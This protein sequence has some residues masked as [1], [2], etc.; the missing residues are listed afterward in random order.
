MAVL[1]RETLAPGPAAARRV[2][3]ALAA[4]TAR[5]GTPATARDDFLLAAS[6]WIV[7]L[8]E[9]PQ[10]PPETVRVTFLLTAAEWRLVMEDSGPAFTEIERLMT[11]SGARADARAD[12]GDTVSE[13]GM[14]LLLIAQA[15]P[16][17]EYAPARTPG[18]CNTL[19]LRC[20]REGAAAHKP[21]V[22][23]VDDD[24]TSLALIS[25]YLKDSYDIET[26]ATAAGALEAASRR[27]PDA[28]ISDIHMPGADGFT[29]RQRFAG[30]PAM[31]GA[32]FI[33]LSA[34]TGA[35]AAARAETLAVDDVIAK[36]VQKDKLLSV[37]RRVLVRARDLRR[38]IET[39][40]DARL[41]ALLR[42]ALAA[43]PAGWRAGLAADPAESGSGDIIADA[44][45]GGA[46]L[47]VFADIMGHGEQA[48]VFAQA[49]AGFV[50]GAAAGAA[51]AGVSSDAAAP[52]LALTALN[53]AFLASPVLS[54]TL[55]TAL[56]AAVFPDGRVVAAA[57][58]HPNPF[59][60]GPA[61]VET[62]AVNG[63]L[64]GLS[65]E[66][67][68]EEACFT[69]APGERLVMVSDGVIEADRADT[70]G[71]WL[72][73]ALAE[74]RAAPPQTQAETILDMARGRAGGAAADDATVLI[75]EPEA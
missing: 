47:I 72:A 24:E 21:R 39:R 33:F 16:D 52:A 50:H 15:F 45:F 56:A 32:P 1:H 68:Y 4:V 6:E 25:A 49:V 22:L 36:P 43:P 69:F 73:Q 75:L 42:P 59:R 20:A 23:L 30:Q 61:G 10:P 41:S 71:A 65:A 29:L 13:S 18:G 26:A 27:A 14:G 64:L 12:S 60:I 3:E 17:W 5:A 19:T 35:E 31:A 44:A 74:T 8:S 57:A 34:D 28:V 53:A 37:L 9:H 67:A 70:D 40:R 62:A 58:G 7:N 66:S 46:R 54:E 11:V 48:A 2:R 51:R 38:R 63:P 55:A